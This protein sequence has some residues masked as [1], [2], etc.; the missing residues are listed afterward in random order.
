MK[1]DLNESYLLFNTYNYSL[2]KIKKNILD[3]IE[4]NIKENHIKNQS[5]IV[6]NLRKREF[7]INFLIDKSLKINL[8]E[9]TL[10]KNIW[11]NI[12]FVLW[13]SI[14]SDCNFSCSYC[15]LNKRKGSSMTRKHVRLIMNFV[16]KY[17]QQLPKIKNLA[18]VYYG[19]E[20]LLNFDIIH[21]FHKNFHS[22]SKKFKINYYA[23]IITNGSLLTPETIQT[24][25]SWN[26][27]IDIQVTIDGD[28]DIQ[29]KYRPFKD[30]GKSFSIVYNNFLYL[31]KNYDGNI[32]LRS[33]INDYNIDSVKKLLLMIKNDIN[34]LVHK[35]NINF[36]W[37]YPNEETIVEYRTPFSLSK[38]QA[39]KLLDLY[40]YSKKLGFR[41]PLTAL[42][43][44]PCILLNRNGYAIDE[45][46]KVYKCPG[47][48]YTNKYYGIINNKGELVL[49]NISNL[50]QY[51]GDTKKCYLT[52]KYGSLCYG[53]CRI[54]RSCPRDYFDTFI[55]E[56][57]RLMI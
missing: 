21:D 13:L 28:A 39:I 54:M 23:S 19:G 35:I 10:Q 3:N 50:F 55:P 46:L 53:G 12:N 14:T 40:K 51:L 30:G 56:Y 15:Y 31:V 43:Q 44:G 48:F 6:K 27:K 17:L 34:E 32:T 42:I 29:N 1:V 47:L 52:C 5:K 49:T 33:N 9:Y 7:L 37:I 2:V 4:K 8:L 57:L 41:T 24:L 26:K 22:I 18:V 36:M 16:K 38:D 11:D 45:S 25:N 20:P